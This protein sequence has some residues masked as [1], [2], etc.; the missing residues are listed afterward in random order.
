MLFR[1]FA[2]AVLLIMASG[3][4]Y[5]WAEW[6]VALALSPE[7]AEAY[8]GQQG[9]IWDAHKDMLLAT[10]GAILA[11][12]ITAAIHR[13]FQRDFNKEWAESLRVQR[14][15]PLGEVEF[16]RLKSRGKS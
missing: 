6:G 2:L 15:E 5:E 14:A 4:V 16:A 10:I 1:S 3:L 8:N 13:A 7:Q 9:D 11:L 12:S